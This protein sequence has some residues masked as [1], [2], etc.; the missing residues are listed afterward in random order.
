M[1]KASRIRFGFLA[2]AGAIELTFFFSLTGGAFADGHA[3]VGESQCED[4]HGAKEAA[5]NLIGPDG[6]P[7][8][9]VAVWQQDAHHTKA[10]DALSND[11]GKRAATKANVGDPTAEGSMC[12]NCHATGAG[13]EGALDPSEGVS[14]E[15]CHGAAADYMKKTVHGEINDDPAKMNVA[16]AAGMLDL[17]KM[18]VREANCKGCHTTQRPCLKP[19]EKAFDVN[20][21]KKFHHWRD[22]VP[23]I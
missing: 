12:L 7:T 11:W 8:N 20:N 1:K 22:H 2:L 4:C 17:R 16:V 14:C 5:K 3:Y 19:G 6:Q 15:A 9:P 21:D 13:K 18:D 10:N 23:V